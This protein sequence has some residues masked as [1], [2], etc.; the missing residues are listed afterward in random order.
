MITDHLPKSGLILC[1]ASGGADSTYLLFRL[2]ELGYS[3][4]AAHYN[5]GIRGEYADRDEAFVRGLCREADIPF[6]SE[7]GDAP[8]CAREHGLGLEDAA[9]R[10]RYDFLE[11][12]ADRLGAS[13]IATAHTAD[14]NAETVLMHLSRGAGLRGLCGIPPVRGRII[15]PMLD[16]THAYALEYLTEHGIPHVEDETNA[17]DDAARNRIRHSVIP[18]L[19]QES[20][21]LAE[22]VFRMTA[23]LREDEAYLTE[24][25]ESFVRDNARGSSLPA[26]LLRDLPRPIAARVIRSMA[27]AGIS[28]AQTAAVLALADSGGFA[29]ISGMRVG[30]SG[31]RIFFGVKESD[32]LPDRTLV[33]GQTLF[34]P[35]AGLS[36][37]AEKISCIPADVH[38]PFNT[39]IFKC[40]SI[41]GN[42]T[43]GAM[44]PGDKIRPAHRN[45]TKELRRL[46]AEADIPAWD[47]LTVPILRDDSGVLGVYGIAAAE[48]ARAFPGDS[49]AVKI[50]FIRE[51][52]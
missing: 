43:V 36:V 39:F 10:L 28:A 35:E 51:E 44:K 6:L 1:A 22:T 7:R 9:R 52:A 4:A 50:D 30:V 27:G 25:V 49:H 41:C 21:A 42:M 29:D 16:E 3:V 11:R 38:K 31:G 26:A 23:L 12:A 15:R 13:V 33:V 46:M 14:D 48:R 24:L 19:K 32:P 45:V 34:L 47:R 18:A 5:H 37:R 17:S 8:A 2:R 20:P 40:E